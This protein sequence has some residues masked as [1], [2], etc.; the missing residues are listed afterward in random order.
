MKAIIAGKEISISLY[1]TATA[2]DLMRVLPTG[3]DFHAFAHEYRAMGRHALNVAHVPMT[4]KLAKN[5]LYYDDRLEALC[6]MKDDVDITPEKRTCLARL[7]AEDVASLDGLEQFYVY[8][9]ND[10]V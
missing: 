8:L 7:S 5:S 6:L 2:E 9:D 3:L 1:Q 4:S 10:E